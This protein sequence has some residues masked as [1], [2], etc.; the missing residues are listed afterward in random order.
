M[1]PSFFST[2]NIK[3]NVFDH[4]NFNKLGFLLLLFFIIGLIAMFSGVSQESEESMIGFG[5]LLLVF[6]V[7]MLK[8]KIKF[9]N[10]CPNCKSNSC[11]YGD[12]S[13]KTSRY[14]SSTSNVIYERE[15]G[16]RIGYYQEGTNIDGAKYNVRE[17]T[18][19]SKSNYYN[20]VCSKCNF[21]VNLEESKSSNFYLFI[22]IF[23][24]VTVGY[25]G[26]Y[27]TGENFYNNY[28]QN[29]K[30]EEMELLLDRKYQ[31]EKKPNKIQLDT[32]NKSDTIQS[33]NNNDF[34]ETDF[35]E[36]YKISKL[37][38][39][40]AKFVGYEEGDLVH[41]IFIDDNKKSY[42]FSVMPSTYQ[43]VIDSPESD[44][45]VAP[46]KKYLN[47]TFDITW[48]FFEPK[49]NAEMEYPFDAVLTIKLLD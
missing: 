28:I 45:G 32:I 6:G 38:S 2:S 20:W 22:I 5:V 8:L 18:L 40:K 35:A 17:E 15:S 10:Y 21:M 30:D 9:N 26:F 27:K 4:I 11:F 29:Q 33:K 23:G 49:F 12:S 24:I 46:N 1:K 19:T 39:T 13:S 41:Y 31:E 34:K 7:Y 36:R 37:Y 48:K 44:Y 43:L 25:F 47:K 14:S 3:R 16:K 42:G